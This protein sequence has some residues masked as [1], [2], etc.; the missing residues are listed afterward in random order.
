MIKVKRFYSKR[1][2]ELAGD[3]ED[4]IKLF[5]IERSQIISINF[6]ADNEFLYAF[7]TWESNKQ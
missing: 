2:F 5:K 3:I 1:S 4:Y 6:T 7:L